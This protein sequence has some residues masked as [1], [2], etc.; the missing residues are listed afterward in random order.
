MADGMNGAT[1]AVL[2]GVYATLALDSFSAFC[3]SPQTTEIN[4]DTREDSL[5]YWVK[6][7]AAFGVGAGAAATII[8]GKPWPLIGAASVSL[9]LW[10]MYKHA[11]N[12]GRSIPGPS[13]ED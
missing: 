8:S 2:L 9:L 7:G 4:I 6:M 13:T 1:A 5:M 10:F 11:A 3:S 12:R